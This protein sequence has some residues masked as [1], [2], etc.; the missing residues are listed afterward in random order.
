MVHVTAGG[1]CRDVDVV[2]LD[3]DGTL[4]DF[5]S[6]W[7]A[8]YARCVAAVVEAAH[9]DNALRAALCSSQPNLSATSSRASRSSCS[10]SLF[11]GAHGLLR[12]RPERTS[13]RASAFRWRAWI[14]ARKTGKDEPA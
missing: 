12:E 10:A 14:V 3:K 5:H 4:T 8:R 6:A 7:G 1:A 13:Q 2:V 9:G 11:D